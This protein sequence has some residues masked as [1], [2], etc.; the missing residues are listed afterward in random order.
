[1]WTA[2]RGDHVAD[3]AH[4]TKLGVEDEFGMRA[5]DKQQLASHRNAAANNIAALYKMMPMPALKPLPNYRN[6]QFV[7]DKALMGP[8]YAYVDGNV[9]L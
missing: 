1:M 7:S 3:V 4:M 9:R 8:S 6:A 2:W 5:E